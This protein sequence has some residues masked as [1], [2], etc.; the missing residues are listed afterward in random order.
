MARS[1]FSLKSFL[2]I[3][4]CMHT[5]MQMPIK[6]RR[7]HEIPGAG[8]PDCV[9][10]L[11]QV[12]WES[13]CKC[14]KPASRPSNPN[15]PLWCWRQ[16]FSMWPLLL[17]VHFFPSWEILCSNVINQSCSLVFACLF[18][19]LDA[20]MI[21]Y[22]DTYHRYASVFRMLWPC[23]FSPFL[24]S[25]C[26]IS[27]ARPSSPSLSPSSCS[28]V[29]VKFSTVF[30][31]WFTAFSISNFSLLVVQNIHL[32]ALP[33][34]VIRWLMFSLMVLAGLPFGPWI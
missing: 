21:F 2:F 6:A 4:T 5:C 23:S 8:F 20:Y 10:H 27:G 15:S 32:L 12:L 3:C 1:S 19:N 18:Y 9:S 31:I 14:S 33:H 7:G 25:G 29:L 26:S 13:Q 24:V 17:A 30:F 22:H 28:D 11:T 34:V 16:G